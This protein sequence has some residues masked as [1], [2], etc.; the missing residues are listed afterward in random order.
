MTLVIQLGEA[1]GEIG[2]GHLR[3]LQAIGTVFEQRGITT[4]TYVRGNPLSEAKWGNIHWIDTSEHLTS[5]LWNIDASVA[6]WSF[7]RAL[8]TNLEKLFERLGKIR[9]WIT[10]QPGEPLAADVVVIPAVL[11]PGSGCKWRGRLLAG[12]DYLPLDIGYTDL[13]LPLAERSHEVL[14][15][16]GGA[17]RTQATLRLL[18]AIAEFDSTV[19]IGPA[20]AHAEAVKQSADELGIRAVQSPDGLDELLRSHCIVITAGG[21]TLTEAAA[22]GTPALVTWEDPH[23]RKQGEVFESM[24]AAVVVGKG[25]RVDPALLYLELSRLLASEEKLKEMASAGRRIADG[26]GA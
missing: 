25:D 12:L 19:V 13:P 11:D 1:D 21:N 7:R 4:D 17:D 20:F 23:E 10:D 8:D 5:L 15:S 18:G 6:V 22:S 14:L 16:L 24:G 26:R 3:E 2:F 9:V